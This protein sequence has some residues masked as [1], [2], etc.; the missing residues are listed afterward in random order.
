MSDNTR[1][2][3]R[4]QALEYSKFF[5]SYSNPK[6]LLCRFL[7]ADYESQHILWFRKVILRVQRLHPHGGG[8]PNDGA[9]GFRLSNCCILQQTCLYIGNHFACFCEGLPVRRNQTDQG[10]LAWQDVLRADRSPGLLKHEHWEDRNVRLTA[11]GWTF[12]W[13]W[14]KEQGG[15]DK[16]YPV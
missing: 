9:H 13:P 2:Q 10:L 6:L 5:F 1:C 14:Q 7:R 15:L 12:Y 3:N 11:R 8:V 4:A 16:R